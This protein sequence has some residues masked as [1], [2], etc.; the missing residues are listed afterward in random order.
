MKNRT[1]IIIF[2]VAILVVCICV[3]IGL[4]LNSDSVRSR[5]NP[6]TVQAIDTS[7]PIPTIIAMTAFAASTQ[8]AIASSPTPFP[9]FTSAP[10]LEVNPTATIYEYLTNTPFILPSQQPPT[11]SSSGGTGNNFDTNG[12]GKVTC[13]DFTTK[14]D[15]TVALHAGYT[16]LDSDGD[17]IPCESLP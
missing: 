16:N 9:T 10:P 6:P 5:I 3:I 15:A 2:V 1:V 13:A 4:A 12:D 17:G 8:T 14:A 11:S 7:I